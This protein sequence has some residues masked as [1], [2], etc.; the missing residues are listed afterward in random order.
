MPCKNR[1]LNLPRTGGIS[2]YCLRLPPKRHAHHS[3]FRPLVLTLA[4]EWIF[5]SSTTG[6]HIIPSTTGYPITI[7]E[8]PSRDNSLRSPP[9]GLDLAQFF[10]DHLHQMARL[11][12]FFLPA[13]FFLR[14]FLF[15]GLFGLE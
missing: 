13:R 15:G 8:A 14:H 9:G 5:Y 4:Q 1:F 6:K 3:Q 11:L 2:V 10:F 12:F 7:S